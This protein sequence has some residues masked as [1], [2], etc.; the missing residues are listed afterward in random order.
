[1]NDDS[2]DLRAARSA[3]NARKSDS[4]LV[5]WV[6]SPEWTMVPDTSSDA[7]GSRTIA[8]STRPLYTEVCAGEINAYTRHIGPE[9]NPHAYTG[10]V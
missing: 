9:V 8:H 6:C 4:S 7:R 2:K 1:V 10:A 3:Y 5:A